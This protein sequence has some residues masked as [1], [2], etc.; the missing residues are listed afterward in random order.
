MVDSRGNKYYFEGKTLHLGLAGRPAGGKRNRRIGV[1]QSQTLFVER[2]PAHFMRAM[3]GW[4]FNDFVF[5]HAADLGFRLVRI[6]IQADPARLLRRAFEVLVLP[7][8]MVAR[9]Q[10][11]HFQKQGF[12]LQGFL[13]EADLHD[14][15]YTRERML[16]KQHEA[17]KPATP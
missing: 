7:E 1:L 16:Q 14:I 17:K 4:G 6:H 3:S 8:D 5:R 9:F 11:L 2:G 13:T 12:E 10:Y 15:R